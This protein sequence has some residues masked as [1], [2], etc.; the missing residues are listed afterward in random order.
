[1]GNQPPTPSQRYNAQINTLEADDARLRSPNGT[2]LF[3]RFSQ[4][5]ATHLSLDGHLL[6]DES[7]N[8]IR[9][10]LN[11][12]LCT[13]YVGIQE[14]IRPPQNNDEL[15]RF[16]I[17][18]ASFY[19]K[20]KT[21]SDSGPI[22]SAYMIPTIPATGFAVINLLAIQST[23]PLLY[24]NCIAEG[25]VLPVLF[26]KILHEL[27]V[28]GYD[29]DGLGQDTPERPTSLLISCDIYYNRGNTYGG[30]FHRDIDTSPIA[31]H[32]AE[33]N[34][35]NAAASF[36]PHDRDRIVLQA[37]NVVKFG[38]RPQNVSLDFF[39][40]VGNV[41]L[42]PEVFLTPLEENPPVRYSDSLVNE[43]FLRRRSIVP[44]TI[45]DF[46]ARSLRVLVQNGTTVLF[47]NYEAI[48]ASP[49]TRPYQV[50]RHDLR[51]HPGLGN[52][53]ERDQ[54]RLENQ[55]PQHIAVGMTENNPRTF[56]RTWFSPAPDGFLIRNYPHVEIPGIYAL[57]QRPSLPV[58]FPELTIGQLFGGSIINSYQNES[59]NLV[60][61]KILGDPKNPIVKV[62]YDVPFEEIKG[63]ENIEKY[64]LR[65]L[66]ILKKLIGKKGGKNNRRKHKKTYNR[67]TKKA[68]KYCKNIKSKKSKK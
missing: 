43:E 29:L 7:K 58:N 21:P 14:P 61:F 45:D 30:H 17:R 18:F 39:S 33:I 53:F 3:A 34:A 46:S 40:P 8:V 10:L 48:H 6:Q 20:I 2:L 25:G 16:S 51:E 9:L 24:A 37:K 23:L 13:S 4:D 54:N 60:N 68:K 63:P 26:K 44:A 12:P 28:L 47:N 52:P 22:I 55:N 57:A 65:E 19:I 15:D 27:K 67:K 32:Y 66:E 64:K 62:N 31:V 1:M 50:L 41:F 5:R 56:L 11:E 49:I 35:L 42:G 59:N 36:N 38:N